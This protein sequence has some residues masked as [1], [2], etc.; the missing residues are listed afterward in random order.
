[1]R[2]ALSGLLLLAF[3]VVSSCELLPTKVKYRYRDRV[4]ID[5]LTVRDTVFV[6]C[7]KPWQHDCHDGR[8]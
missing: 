4:V 7:P 8:D 3:V 6:P 1:M 5:T 2:V